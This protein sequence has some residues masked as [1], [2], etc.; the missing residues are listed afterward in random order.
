MSDWSVSLMVLLRKSF[1][2]ASGAPKL[3]LARFLKDSIEEV[4]HLAL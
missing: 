4:V 3:R 1:I 2:W